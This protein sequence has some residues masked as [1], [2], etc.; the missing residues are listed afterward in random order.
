MA[1]DWTQEYFGTGKYHN[2]KIKTEDGTFDSKYEYE[3]WCRLKLLERGGVIRNLLRQVPYVLIPTIRTTAGTLKQITYYADF[4]YEENGIV[5]MVDT[6]GYETEVFK[7][8]KRLLINQ[9]VTEQRIFIER[10]KGKKDKIYQ[11]SY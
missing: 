3:E 5:C 10:K 1:R 7:I 2:K 4:V 8:K 6:K 9:Y 11:K